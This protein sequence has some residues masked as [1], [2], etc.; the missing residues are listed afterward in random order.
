M[1][2]NTS[3]YINRTF[4]GDEIFI[5]RDNQLILVYTEY[6]RDSVRKPGFVETADAELDE[7]EL[8][9]ALGYLPSLTQNPYFWLWLESMGLFIENTVEEKE[10]EYHRL[11]LGTVKTLFDWDR[12]CDITGTNPWCLNEG[13]CDESTVFQVTTKQINQLK[14]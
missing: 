8:E 9:V 6:E 7:I 5:S 14:K 11:S 1:K 4:L 3:F 2:S 12:F 13:M 10:V